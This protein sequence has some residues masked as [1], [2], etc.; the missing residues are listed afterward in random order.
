M[1]LHQLVLSLKGNMLFWQQYIPYSILNISR[2]C[3]SA[4]S[5]EQLKGLLFSTASRYL[6]K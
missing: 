1:F 2:N 4:E 3:S 5:Q 6:I